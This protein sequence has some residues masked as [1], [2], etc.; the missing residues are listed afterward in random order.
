MLAISVV[1]G[2]S[3]ERD[4]RVEGTLILP[5]LGRSSPENIRG[6]TYLRSGQHERATEVFERGLSR[7][8]FHKERAYFQNALAAAKLAQKEYLDALNL[9]RNGRSTMAKVIQLH[10]YSA[11]GERKAALGFYDELRKDPHSNVIDLSEEIARQFRLV[12]GKPSHPSAWI[13]DKEQELLLA[14]AA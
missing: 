14:L 5:M 4:A 9:S 2:S 1:R 13:I 11:L 7:M 12:P 6:M 8:Q 10:S 3:H